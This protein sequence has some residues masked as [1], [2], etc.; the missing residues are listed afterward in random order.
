MT[1]KVQQLHKFRNLVMLESVFG[2]ILSGSLNADGTKNHVI[3]T[4]VTN[5]LRVFATDR[6]NCEND[7][8]KFWDLE[9]LGIS[10]KES[11]CYDN[12][13]NSFKKF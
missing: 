11:S 12:Y 1:R 8:C 5:V 3:N 7:V 9:T 10:E 6:Y 13:L 4:N 2:W